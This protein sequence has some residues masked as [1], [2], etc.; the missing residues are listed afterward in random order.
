MSNNVCIGIG[1][2]EIFIYDVESIKYNNDSHLNIAHTSV[3]NIIVSDSVYNKLLSGKQSVIAA[4]SGKGT[5]SPTLLSVTGYQQKDGPFRFS[6][7]D[8]IG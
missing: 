2:Y 8:Q 5:Y 6:L 7:S 1:T 3:G 4:L